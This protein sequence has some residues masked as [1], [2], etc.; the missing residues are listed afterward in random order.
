M[1]VFLCV[2]VTVLLISP[3]LAKPILDKSGEAKGYLLERNDVP[4][5]KLTYLRPSRWYFSAG[6]DKKFAYVAS[7]TQR[8]WRPA[9]YTEI[10]VEVGI[11][12][13][14]VDALQAAELRVNTLKKKGRVQDQSLKGGQL[15]GQAKGDRVWGLWDPPEPGEKP[16]PGKGVAPI[17]MFGTVVFVKQEVCVQV[18]ARNMTNAV[19]LDDLEQLAKKI[20]VKIKP[21]NEPPGQKDKK[22]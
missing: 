10:L 4:E 2:L 1:R 8:W 7:L 5:L 16:D 6:G 9:D 3:V 12:P 21:A 18:T 20:A 19:S 13:S 15:P 14:Q 17:S 22:K 11:F